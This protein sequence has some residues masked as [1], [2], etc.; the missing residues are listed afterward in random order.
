MSQVYFNLAGGNL[1]QDW[2]NAGLIT[3]NDDWSNVPSFQGFL[4]QDITT[5]TGTNPGTLLADFTVANDLDVIANQANPNTL[6]SG[7][8]AE[9]AI[10]DPTIALQGSGTADAPHLVMYLNATGRQNVVVF[11]AARD[12]DGSTDN[13]VQPLAVQY[14]LGETG[15]WTN[16]PPAGGAAA[17]PQIADATSGP[18]LAT[19]VTPITVTLP[20]A[21]DNQ[22]Q[23]QVRFITANA[24]GNDEWVGI[25]N[26]NVTSDQ[27]PQSIGFA[28]GSLLVAKS[29]GDA[30][31]TAFTFTVERIGATD[32][33]V[34]F[35]V[36]LNSATA[37][38]A[39][40]SGSPALPL[41]INGTILAGQ[42]TATVTVNVNGDTG[43][44]VN[45]DFTLAITSVT[46]ATAPAVINSNLDEATGRILADDFTGTDIGGVA[47]LPE[48]ASLQGATVTPTAT[49]AIELV[50]LGSYRGGR[51]QRRGRVVRPDHGP[52]LHPQYHRQ[53]D[54]DRADRLV[55]RTHQDRRDQP[56]RPDRLRR[57]Q[58]G[59]D[60]ERHRGGGLRQQRRPG[61]T[62]MSRCSTPPGLCK[63]QS[64]SACCRTW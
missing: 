58:F 32:G 25:D 45:E 34:D 35:T 63:T 30:G 7:G 64:R 12:I 3:T 50:R 21:V 37:N 40:F 4:G 23:V 15:P 44:E 18:S 62:V 19:Q 14:R 5:A 26:I 28:S 2:S 53:Q 42:Q 17:D 57:R 52:A 33:D 55:G 29:E 51:R 56:G 49:N 27:A 46:N 48:A 16:F 20:S 59:R 8:V 31:A 60:Q 43:V 22:A 9:F 38:S 13:A 6:T 1:V 11:F 61:T 41:A 10:A 47:V 24:A 36:N 54:R 39:D